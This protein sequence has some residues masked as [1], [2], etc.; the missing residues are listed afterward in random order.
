MSLYVGSNAVSDVRVGSTPVQFVYA[1]NQLVW[2]RVSILTSPSPSVTGL[3]DL[4]TS[5][6]TTASATVTLTTSP[7]T[8]VSWSITVQSGSTPTLGATSGT[9]TTVR[10]ERPA[11]EGAGTT[12][13]TV[14]VFAS[15]GG[16]QVA[17]RTV[18]VTAIQDFL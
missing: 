7:A 12:T 10:I 17:S 1:G 18:T 2:A 4:N 15:I 9:G 5:P 16:A 3:N 11:S 14:A 8:S 13:S 6:N